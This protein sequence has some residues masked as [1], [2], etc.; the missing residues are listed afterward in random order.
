MFSM[1]LASLYAGTSTDTGS[2]T[3]GPQRKPRRRTRRAWT[4]ES[5]SIRAKRPMTR[6]PVAARPTTRTPVRVSEACTSRIQA[7]PFHR[8]A[9]VTSVCAPAAPRASVRVSNS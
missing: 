1:H 3:A 5:R 6:N 2:V 8:P 9:P 4:P 7:L